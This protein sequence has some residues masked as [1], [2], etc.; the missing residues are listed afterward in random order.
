M[1]NHLVIDIIAHIR[2]MVES[3]VFARGPAEIRVRE[4]EEDTM[5]DTEGQYEDGYGKPPAGRHLQRGQSGNSRAPRGKNMAAQLVA[6][7]NESAS[8]TTD[9]RR[10]KI[11]KRDAVVGGLV[12]TP[13]LDG[14]PHRS[15][16]I[17]RWTRQPS[18][19]CATAAALHRLAVG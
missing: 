1:Q 11:T 13:L 12:K 18:A 5:S 10:R 9:G 17:A 8:A 15:G 7:L 2:Y 16:E 19:R 14:R 3:S 4:I 6:V